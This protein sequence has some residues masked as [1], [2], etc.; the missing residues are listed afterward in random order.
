LLVGYTAPNYL[1]A[2][3]IWGPERVKSTIRDGSVSLHLGASL[4]RAFADW[5]PHVEVTAVSLEF[6]TVPPIDV[7]RSLRIENW[8]HHHGG[9][10]HPKER[11]I[12]LR[13]LR[14]F[15]PDSDEWEA[16]VWRQGKEV[17]E[18]VLAG[19]ND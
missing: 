14:A 4:K 12:K 19:M 3:S 13:L 7:F 16:L 17:V 6:G 2:L 5:L 1:R 10:G 18:Q 8:L 9:G 11:K 15:H